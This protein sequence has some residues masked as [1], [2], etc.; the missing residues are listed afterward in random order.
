MANRYL[1]QFQYTL[2]QDSV[3]LY[4]AFVVGAAGAVSSTKGGGILSVVKEATAGQYSV[5]LTDKWS[6][7]LFV[8]ACQVLATVSQVEKVQVLESS[9]SLQTAV[10]AGTA[11]K[12]QFLGFTSSSDPTLV[13]TNPDSGTQVQ[14]KITVRNSSVGRFD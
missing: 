8:E 1:K 13:A 7:L 14:L 4:G 3:T 5:T 10:T 11:F 6:K 2:E 12:L 9:T